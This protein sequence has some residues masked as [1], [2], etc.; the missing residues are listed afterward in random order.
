MQNMIFDSVFEVDS[1][2][3]N[4]S[5]FLKVIDSILKKESEIIKSNNDAGTPLVASTSPPPPF[6]HFWKVTYF[7]TKMKFLTIVANDKCTN[8]KA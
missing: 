1:V 5:V 3:E 8:F 7:F 4:K 2:L 6:R